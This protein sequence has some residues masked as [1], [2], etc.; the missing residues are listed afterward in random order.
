[1]ATL[2]IVS[3]RLGKDISKTLTLRRSVL[4]LSTNKDTVP[5]ATYRKK[6]KQTLSARKVRA[7]L[8]R[9]CQA[10]SGVRLNR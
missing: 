10:E 9:D 8:S 3:V 7:P 5:T 1:M 4:P 6:S 2:S